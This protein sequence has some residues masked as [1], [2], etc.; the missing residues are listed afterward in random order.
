MEVESLRLT[1]GGYECNASCPYCITKVMGFKKEHEMN[2]QRFNVACNYAKLGGAKSVIISSQGEP[3]IYH[4]QVS[5]VLEKLKPYNFPIIQLQTN[6]Y[7]LSRENYNNHLKDWINNGLTSIL[8]SVVSHDSEFNSKTMNLPFYDIKEAAKKL[9][10][11]GY[12]VRLSCIMFKGGIDS[13]ESLDELVN[14]SKSNKVEH[15][16]IRHVTKP[17]ETSKSNEAIKWV[18]EHELADSDK[19]AIFKHVDSKGTRIMRLSFGGIVYDLYG[20]N[21]AFIEAIKVNAEEEK[22]IELSLLPNGIIN[23]NKRYRGAVLL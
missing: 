21:L 15:L 12:S 22:S 14:F 8:L 23:Y 11:F 17:Y 3:S 1:I 20:Q 6:G 10:G 16:T 13:P 19:E 4:R 5:E 9:H 2:W 7:L 18:N